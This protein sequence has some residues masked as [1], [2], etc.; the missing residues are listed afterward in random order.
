MTPFSLEI[1]HLPKCLHPCCL[2]ILAMYVLV[3]RRIKWNSQGFTNSQAPLCLPI[4]FI[5]L[6]V[7]SHV[8]LSPPNLTKYSLLRQFCVFPL[9]ARQKINVKDVIQFFIKRNVKCLF[10]FHFL[11]ILKVLLGL[12][13]C[14]RASHSPSPSTK[15]DIEN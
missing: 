4:H 3:C 5:W 13:S 8:R 10:L 9:S 11:R 12:Y 7:D 14:L 6:Y 2:V 15:W 1:T